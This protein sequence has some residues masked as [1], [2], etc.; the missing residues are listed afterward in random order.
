MRII[1]LKQYQP[2][3]LYFRAGGQEYFKIQVE[4]GAFLFD[5]AGDL[6]HVPRILSLDSLACRFFTNND[7]ILVGCQVAADGWSFFECKVKSGELEVARY[8]GMLSPAESG[9]FRAIG[10]DGMPVVHREALKRINAFTITGKKGV[11]HFVVIDPVTLT[12]LAI[13]DSP[14]F[15]GSSSDG[16][17][18]SYVT[19]RHKLRPDLQW[20]APLGEALSGAIEWAQEGVD[21]ETQPMDLR[22]TSLHLDGHCGNTKLVRFKHS[23]LD[24]FRTAMDRPERLDE[25]MKKASLSKWE[26]YPCFNNDSLTIAVCENG[27]FAIAL[28]PMANASR[29]VRV[30]HIGRRLP[31]DL[32]A[33]DRLLRSAGIIPESLSIM[34]SRKDH[35]QALSSANQV[36]KN[37]CSASSLDVNNTESSSSIKQVNVV[38]KR[39]ESPAISK[40][41][42]PQKKLSTN[43]KKTKIP[44]KEKLVIH[45]FSRTDADF[46]WVEASWSRS[47]ET[48]HR[49]IFRVKNNGQ[50]D[51]QIAAEMLAIRRILLDHSSAGIPITIGAQDI[52]LIVSKGAIK[53]MLRSDSEKIKGIWHSARYLMARCYGSK[54]TVE[55]KSPLVNADSV[56]VIDIDL[57]VVEKEE[58]L[59]TV[60]G[61]VRL[62]HHAIKRVMER[63]TE[64]ETNAWAY[65]LSEL[66]DAVPGG[67]SSGFSK[68]KHERDAQYLVCKSWCFVVGRDRAGNS[69]VVY[70][71]YPNRKVMPKIPSRP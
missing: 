26:F 22:Y 49:N 46:C 45:T 33:L 65:A 24:S 60:I 19:V 64:Q 52:D 1:P 32:L 62:S 23:M 63:R 8:V 37:I 36:Q 39:K 56:P 10:G 3:H 48:Q 17:L 38:V 15:C 69:Q 58:M 47:G 41:T 5:R 9:S 28:A 57:H 66:K 53:K 44:H 40:Y 51:T 42:N 61:L 20:V 71:A 2:T 68:V 43:E 18:T 6:D 54:V 34:K 70:T 11:D 25:L 13:N 21:S 7:Q 59:D 14:G 31:S 29:V 27:D 50:G 16:Q 4:A 55:K 12:S 35:R 67:E 30:S